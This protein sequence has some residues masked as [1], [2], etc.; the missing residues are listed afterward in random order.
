MVLVFLKYSIQTT[1]RRQEKMD[2][3]YK[4]CALCQCQY[5]AMDI[6]VILS[7]ELD[8]RENIILSDAN[9]N[10]PATFFFHSFFRFLL[11]RSFMKSG[12]RFISHNFK[13]E[14]IVI[15]FANRSNSDGSLDE[16]TRKWCNAPHAILL[17]Q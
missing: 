7:E 12:M 17:K 1:K 3:K 4:V 16:W 8:K 9:N 14:I 11:G 2:N 10:F 15:R 5:Q 13:M 6:K